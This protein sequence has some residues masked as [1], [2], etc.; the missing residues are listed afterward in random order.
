MSKSYPSNL[1]LEQ[2]ELLSSLI[3]PESSTGRLGFV[4]LRAVIS[5]IFYILCAGCAWRILPDDFPKWQTY[6]TTFANGGLMAHGKR[7]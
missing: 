3:P 5:A 6:I 1:T 7:S 4:N 2:W